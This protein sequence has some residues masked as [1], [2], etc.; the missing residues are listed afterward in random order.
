MCVSKGLTGVFLCLAI[1]C[2]LNFTT[3][4][5]DCHGNEICDNLGY[6][7]AYIGNIAD[8]CAH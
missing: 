5:L 2:Q 1:K 3:T 4:D 8:A 6:N 7:S